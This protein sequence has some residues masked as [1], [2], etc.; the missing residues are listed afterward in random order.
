MRCL[1]ATGSAVFEEVK[2]FLRIAKWVYK[3]GQML[4][5]GDGGTCD[6]AFRERDL[7]VFH[8]FA[9]FTVFFGG[10]EGRVLWVCHHYFLLSTGRVNFEPTFPTWNS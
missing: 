4:L 8:A 7:Y 5:L 2:R 10:V 1:N 3:A 6:H 9:G